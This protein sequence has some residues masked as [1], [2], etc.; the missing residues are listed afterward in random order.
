MAA[1]AGAFCVVEVLFP[2]FFDRLRTFAPFLRWLFGIT[3]ILSV[4]VSSYGVEALR[5]SGPVP[6][7]TPAL[8]SPRPLPAVLP[9][10][11]V[12]VIC[13][14]ASPQMKDPTQMPTKMICES[15]DTFIV[16]YRAG[17]GPAMPAK[18]SARPDLRL[19]KIHAVGLHQHAFDYA[20]ELIKQGH[21][22]ADGND[23][24]DTAVEMS[25]NVV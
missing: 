16:V 21:V 1:A 12:P 18:L 3:I 7:I 5:G 2:I 14:F 13:P 17:R 10:V 4:I 25:H 19:K 20:R 6:V 22:V 23:R 9:V 11:P 8:P 24:K 15:L